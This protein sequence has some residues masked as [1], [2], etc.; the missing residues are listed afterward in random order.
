MG[1]QCVLKTK[2]RVPRA[3][4]PHARPTSAQVAG[5]RGM[6]KPSFSSLTR[7]GRAPF[8]EASPLRSFPWVRSRQ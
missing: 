1:L 2:R 4:R 7:Q 5:A 8:A 6:A 3:P